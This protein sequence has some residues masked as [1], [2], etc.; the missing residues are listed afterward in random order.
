MRMFVNMTLLSDHSMLLKASLSFPLALSVSWDNI[1]FPAL[2]MAS[3]PS[4]AYLLAPFLAFARRS[5]LGGTEVGVVELC[6]DRVTDGAGLFRGCNGHKE[7]II[8]A[9]R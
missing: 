8:Y 9:L 3:R 4:E 1:F 7:N 2:V 6:E 5:G